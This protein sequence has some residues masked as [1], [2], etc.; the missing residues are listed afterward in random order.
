MFLSTSTLNA[1]NPDILKAMSLLSLIISKQQFN[2]FKVVYQ[3]VE[4]QVAVAVGSLF[5]IPL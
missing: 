1:A 2:N 4:C 3:V 5:W